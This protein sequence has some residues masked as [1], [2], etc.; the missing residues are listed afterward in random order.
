MVGLE[1]PASS[2]TYSPPSV[3]NSVNEGGN[4]EEGAQLAQTVYEMMS[5]TRKGSGK[6]SREISEGS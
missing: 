6:E 4:C 5:T 1:G 2:H 3:Q